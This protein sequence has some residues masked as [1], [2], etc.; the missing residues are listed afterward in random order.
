MPSREQGTAS[1][2]LTYRQRSAQVLGWLYVAVAALLAVDLLRSW[3]HDP[4]VAF[5]VWLVV[6]LGVAWTVFLRPYVRVDRDGVTLGNVLRDV[7]IPWHLVE[8][9]R[10]R[11]NLEVFT[12]ERRYTSWAISTQVNRPKSAIGGALGGMAGGR[13]M[14][15]EPPPAAG[16][17]AAGGATSRAVADVIENTRD[18]YAGAVASGELPRPVDAAVAVRWQ[19]AAVAALVVPLVAVALLVVA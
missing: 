8:D 16:G 18:D 17:G 13:R 6:G 3:S 14:G 4:N 11:W 5:V 2:Q 9:V 10:T 19:P 1:H 7:F 15:F 12:P